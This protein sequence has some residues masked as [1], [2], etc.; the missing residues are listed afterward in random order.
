MNADR[1]LA[2]RAAAGSLACAAVLWWTASGADLARRPGLS[3]DAARALW[4]DALSSRGQGR[5][6]AALSAVG[7]LLAAYPGEPRYLGLQT[8]ILELAHRPLDAARS[9]ER[10]LLVAPFPTDACPAIGRDYS[11]AGLPER[12]LDADR[13]CLALDPSK[14]DLM[15]YYALA[16]ERAGRGAEAEPLLREAL[17][18]DP[19]DADA[20]VALAR[21]R[22]TASDLDGADAILAPMLALHA[23]DSD[24]LLMAARVREERGDLQGA[25]ALLERA[26]LS[27]PGYADVRRILARVLA[28][29]GDDEGARRARAAAASIDAGAPR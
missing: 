23:D 20:A 13:R 9:W 6:R 3:P 10:F 11:K 14:P 19:K 12:E 18:Q 29:A 7:E 25:R 1:R 2:A 5:M 22:I 15:V 24:V 16:L 21:L 28:K 4:D 26:V 17:R 8:E 27:S